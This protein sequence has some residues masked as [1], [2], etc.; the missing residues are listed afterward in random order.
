[1]HASAAEQIS[2]SA[3]KMLERRGSLSTYVLVSIRSVLS[4][5]TIILTTFETDSGTIAI[6]VLTSSEN[7]TLVTGDGLKSVSWDRRV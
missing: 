5:R 1:M 3:G 6:H 7:K 4:T 2:R